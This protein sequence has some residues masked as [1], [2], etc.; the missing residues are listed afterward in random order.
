MHLSFRRCRILYLKQR[1]SSTRSHHESLEWY[2]LPKPTDD[3]VK[4]NLINDDKSEKNFLRFYDE[5]S[6][7]QIVKGLAKDSEENFP[8]TF[9]K[10]GMPKK[11]QRR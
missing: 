7:R 6:I 1:R 11:S 4:R 10:E 8:V 5:R 9:R 3:K 2:T